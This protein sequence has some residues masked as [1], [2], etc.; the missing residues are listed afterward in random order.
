MRLSNKMGGSHDGTDDLIRRDQRVSSLSHPSE[1]Y[2]ETVVCN[3][4][5]WA[6]TETRSAGSFALDLQ[7]SVTVRTNLCDLSHS[8]CST[9]L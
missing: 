1:Y 7:L 6:S 2:E 5:S 3:P 9:L 4:G 8:V